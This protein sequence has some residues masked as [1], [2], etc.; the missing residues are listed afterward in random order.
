MEIFPLNAEDDYYDSLQGL[1]RI[2]VPVLE[3]HYPS[4]QRSRRISS[5]PILKKITSV[6]LNA[7][8]N[9]LVSF[10]GS[11][12]SPSFM[13]VLEVFTFLYSSAQGLHFPPYVC[14][15]RLFISF[16]CWRIS[17]SFIPVLSAITSLHSS[18]KGDHFITFQ[19]SRNLP[20]DVPSSQQVVCLSWSFATCMVSLRLAILLQVCK[21]AAHRGGCPSANI[22]RTKCK[23]IV[24]EP[25]KRHR[26]TKSR[27]TRFGCPVLTVLWPRLSPISARN[28]TERRCRGDS[29]V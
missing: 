7:S 24:F 16:E 13:L 11:M 23:H 29:G 1:V 3:S 17:F 21:A 22:P 26:L 8:G 15:M 28:L 9:R 4:L 12:R 14:C 20:C 10:Q 18:A 19:C 27:G 6:L 2:F 25:T 5:R